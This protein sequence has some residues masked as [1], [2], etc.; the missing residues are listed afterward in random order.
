MLSTSAIWKYSSC[1]EFKTRKQFMHKHIM[2]FLS[3]YLLC[4]VCCCSFLFGFYYFPFI[5]L[6]FCLWLAGHTSRHMLE[7]KQ[8]KTDARERKAYLCSRNSTEKA[9]T[10][11]K[12]VP[13]SVVFFF[14]SENMPVLNA[15]ASYVYRGSYLIL[16]HAVRTF[17]DPM[18]S[19]TRS[20]AG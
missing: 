7:K 9:T 10:T 4:F 16:A 2:I 12:I 3:S 18:E 11:P 19:F 15:E 13:M 8:T 17:H 6:P 20:I 1:H 5:F 14:S